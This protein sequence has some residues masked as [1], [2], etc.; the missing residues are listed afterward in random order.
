MVSWQEP[1]IRFPNNT[2][3]HPFCQAYF[4]CLTYFTLDI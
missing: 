3:I 4:H 2:R 1:Q